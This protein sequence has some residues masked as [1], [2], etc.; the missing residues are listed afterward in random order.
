MVQSR[1]GKSS[2]VH[3]VSPEEYEGQ[4]IKEAI[5]KSTYS[6]GQSNN[7]YINVKSPGHG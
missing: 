5:D 6:K 1:A 7:W 2:Q 4:Y 3:H